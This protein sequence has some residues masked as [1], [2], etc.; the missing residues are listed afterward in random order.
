MLKRFA[1]LIFLASLGFCAMGSTP[2]V[3]PNDEV[4]QVL[5]LNELLIGNLSSVDDVDWYSISASQAGQLQVHIQSEN[6]DSAGWSLTIWDSSFNQ[7]TATTCLY[8]IC[9]EPG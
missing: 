4:A 9:Q 3:E 8:E 6:Y 2:E 7:L 5:T 1:I